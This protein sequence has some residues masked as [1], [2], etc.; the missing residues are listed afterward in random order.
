M[1]TIISFFLLSISLCANVSQPVTVK[2]EEAY[3]K[4]IK[5]LGE[6]YISVHSGKKIINLKQ[7]VEVYKGHNGWSKKR[8]VTIVLNSLE[9][10][11]DGSLPRKA[12]IYW[13][14]F[15]P[16]KWILLVQDAK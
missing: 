12:Y 6:S 15:T 7:V 10:H 11:P 3:P 2:K 16:E 8:N 9:H 14:N 5:P 1:K 13:P 4:N